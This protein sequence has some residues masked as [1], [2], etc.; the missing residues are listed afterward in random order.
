M[1]IA[2]W[3]NKEDELTC[4]KKKVAEQEGTIRELLTE[5]SYSPLSW[6]EKVFLSIGIILSSGIAVVG[7]YH[8][9]LAAY[10][11]GLWLSS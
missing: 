10:Q 6:E 9:A 1:K 2:P 5:E 8:V 4:L 11:F 7:T 3:I